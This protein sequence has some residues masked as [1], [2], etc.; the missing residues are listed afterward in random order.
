MSAIPQA[1]PPLS[2]EASSHS[3]GPQVPRLS[4]NEWHLSLA[5][6]PKPT[7]TSMQFLV[8]YGYLWFLLIQLLEVSAKDQQGFFPILLI[9]S[10]PVSLPVVSWDFGTDV[11]ERPGDHL[12]LVTGIWECGKYIYWLETCERMK[13]KHGRSIWQFGKRGFEQSTPK[14]TKKRTLIRHDNDTNLIYCNL[15]KPETAGGSVCAV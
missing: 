6:G 11:H 4:G 8:A 12:Q 3:S 5:S 7:S 15:F 1:S 9:R 14:K 13:E 10:S 2:L